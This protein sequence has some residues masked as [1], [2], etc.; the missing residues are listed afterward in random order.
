MA[1]L[2]ERE[3]VLG[4]RFP[5]AAREWYS[6]EGAVEILATYSN[7]DRPL[8]IPNLGVSPWDTLLSNGLLVFMDE[9]QGVHQWGVQLDGSDDPPVHAGYY[10]DL[11]NWEIVTDNFST[12]VYC[13]VWDWAQ[14]GRMKV[15][16][17][18]KSR[19]TSNHTCQGSGGVS[20]RDRNRS[21]TLMCS[22]VSRALMDPSEF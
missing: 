12:F 3:R 8:P 14:R 10:K 16:S 4:I 5:A 7:E 15:I 2:D 6:L 1:L 13:Y 17:T 22:I 18:W 21:T 11:T 19:L 20:E 9:N